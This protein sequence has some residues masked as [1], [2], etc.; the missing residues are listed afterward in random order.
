MRTSRLSVWPMVALVLW[1]GCTSTKS[2]WSSEPA[3]RKSGNEYFDTKLSAYC[4]KTG[5][6]GFSLSLE[7]KGP[8][9]IDVD[10]SRT[11]YLKN[12]VEAGGFTFEGI[13]LKGKRD[14]KPL[15]TVVG[16]GILSKKIV[17][18]MLTYPG[19]A[20][21]PYMEPG[22]HGIRLVVKADGREIIERLVINILR[23]EV[24]E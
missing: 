24:P 5:C 12:G 9:E 20:L 13:I 6:L 23:M 14:S 22:E 11:V 15:E 18:D 1:V 4:E 2:L 16:Y 17:P 21:H 8:K 19:D 3:I 7:N 10:W